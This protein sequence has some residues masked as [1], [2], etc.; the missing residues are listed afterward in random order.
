[1]TSVWEIQLNEKIK[2]DTCKIVVAKP[3]SI[4]G[5]WTPGAFIS[6]ASLA[7]VFEQARMKYSWFGGYGNM[8]LLSDT[9]NQFQ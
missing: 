3:S 7:G 4:Q 5:T 8:D 2:I 1:M 9:N 6:A